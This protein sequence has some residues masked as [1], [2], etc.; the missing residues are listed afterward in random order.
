MDLSVVYFCS[1]QVVL[2]LLASLN[3]IVYDAQVAFSIFAQKQHFAILFSH[4][5][6]SKDSVP[7]VTVCVHP[8]IE[9][10]QNDEFIAAGRCLNNLLQ[11]VESFLPLGL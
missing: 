9:A 2:Y 8:S 7:V 6:S 5:V 1:N 3:I 4:L 10:S 11:V